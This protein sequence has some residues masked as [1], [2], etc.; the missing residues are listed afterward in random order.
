MAQEQ[1]LLPAF[2]GQLIL[3]DAYNYERDDVTYLEF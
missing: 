3:S 1:E 2:N